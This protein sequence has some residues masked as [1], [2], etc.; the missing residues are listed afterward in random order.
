M[1]LF[2]VL[3]ALSALLIGMLIWYVVVRLK[4]LSGELTQM[5]QELRTLNGLLNAH[6]ASS[7]G[8]HRRLLNLEQEGVSQ[9]QPAS[10]P[11][12]LV[13]DSPILVGEENSAHLPYAK[14]IDRIRQGASAQELRTEMGL[15]RDEAELLY[16]LH[17]NT[18]AA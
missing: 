11:E 16:R 2:E 1:M 13:Q 9:P 4:R 7:N 8:L 10:N 14:A 3:L 17:A 15:S 18:P 6:A 12:P 5:R